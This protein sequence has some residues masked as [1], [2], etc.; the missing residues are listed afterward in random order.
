MFCSI[1]CQDAALNNFHRVECQILPSFLKLKL[2]ERE[3]LAVRMLLLATK[4]GQ[5]MKEFMKDPDFSQPFV[6]RKVELNKK[7]NTKNYHIICNLEDKLTELSS[8]DFS[9]IYLQKATIAAFLLHILKQSKVFTGAVNNTPNK[10][11]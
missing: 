6:K 5:E 8:E 4:Q 7:Y 11:C 2:S 1:K 3:I 9:H 10:V